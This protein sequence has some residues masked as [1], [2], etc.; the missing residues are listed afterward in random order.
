MKYYAGFTT[1]GMKI[2]TTSNYK[3]NTVLK[4]YLVNGCYIERLFN[5][6]DEVIKY[7]DGYHHEV[8]LPDGK[9]VVP[10]WVNYK[11]AY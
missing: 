1:E 8:T 3:Y 4:K 9:T 10:C 7:L 5:T 2:L 6:V 11:I